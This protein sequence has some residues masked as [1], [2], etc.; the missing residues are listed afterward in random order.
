MVVC[1]VH[2]GQIEG[3]E[4]QS[5]QLEQRI[6][7]VDNP[8]SDPVPGGKR[9]LSAVPPHISTFD[10]DIDAVSDQIGQQLSLGGGEAVVIGIG[11]GSHPYP[12]QIRGTQQAITGEDLGHHRRGESIE[13]QR[14]GDGGGGIDVASATLG[15]PHHIDG[16]DQRTDH[17]AVDDAAGGDRVVPAS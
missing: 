7:S 12:L 17:I 14:I 13:H 5:D 4:G 10:I 9:G 3:I 8:V 16:V 11:P 15:G 6:I 1:R 2:S